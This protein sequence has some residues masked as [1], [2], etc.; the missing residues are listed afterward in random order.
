MDG[1]QQKIAII[2]AGAV[3]SH[4]IKAWQEISGAEVI[5]ICRRDVA[6]DR[7]LAEKFNLY[8]C[9]NYEKILNNPDVDV[10]DITL[11][12]GMHAD[13]GIK[14]AQAGK[15]V[16]VEKP[17]DV[18]LEKADALIEACDRAGVT[19]AVISQYRFMDPVLR[20]YDLVENGRLG[21]LLQ[22][23]A[24]IKWYRSQEYYDSGS[25]RGHGN[26]MAAGHLSIR[27]FTS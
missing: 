23:D 10:V 12:S 22:G 7:E 4:H 15:H 6:S 14:A 24:Y 13:F 8:S 19:L 1:N 26:W 9:T 17:I 11:P 16:I 25:W 3:T 5:G 18:S 27:G 21:E 2:G 20:M